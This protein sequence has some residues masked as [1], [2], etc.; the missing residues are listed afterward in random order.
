MMVEARDLERFRHRQFHFS[1]ERDQMRRRNAAIAILN[2]MQMLDQEIAPAWFGTEQFAHFGQ[3]SR[4][5]N[6][7]LGLAGRTFE[8]R[9]ARCVSGLQS[10]VHQDL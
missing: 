3:R 4:L 8:G 9:A 6:A 10:I 1:G 7:S 5:G 2:F